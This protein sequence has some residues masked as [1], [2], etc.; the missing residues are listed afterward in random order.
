[1]AQTTTSKEELKLIR[2]FR[3]FIAVWCLA[4]ASSVYGVVRLF[5]RPFGEID[6]IDIEGIVVSVVQIIF[7][8]IG[9]SPGGALWCHFYPCL[10]S[11]FDASTALVEKVPRKSG[12]KSAPPK[13]TQ[14]F[15]REGSRRIQQRAPN[16]PRLNAI[17]N[18]FCTV[19][20]LYSN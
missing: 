3:I 10:F 8:V 12:E 17:S 18:T 13:P 16:V 14:R 19:I 7:S 9:R 4:F 5:W 15:S 1:M 11:H 2:T 6:G 20:K